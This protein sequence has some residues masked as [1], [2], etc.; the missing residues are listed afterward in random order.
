MSPLRPEKWHC[1]CDGTRVSKANKTFP[2][3]CRCF[4]FRCQNVLKSSKTNKH[5]PNRKDLYTFFRK[6]QSWRSSTD[7]MTQ[8]GNLFFPTRGTVRSPPL[9]LS[10]IVPKSPSSH[11][12]IVIICSWSSLQ[13][14]WPSQGLKNKS[15]DRP[16]PNCVWELPPGLMRRT[17]PGPV[18]FAAPFSSLAGSKGMM[19]VPKKSLSKLCS[20]ALC[21]KAAGVRNKQPLVGHNPVG[22]ESVLLTRSPGSS[23]K[24]KSSLFKK[25][26]FIALI[27]PLWSPNSDNTGKWRAI[28]LLWIYFYCLWQVG[29]HL[30][31]IHSHPSSSR[32]L[33]NRQ[34]FLPP[35]LQDCHWPR[36]GRVASGAHGCCLQA[37][38]QF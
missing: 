37:E 32:W 29:N 4:N 30:C 18:G 8:V 28:C 2:N 23:W 27:V 35:S 26:M 15:T 3:N 33:Q 16:E 36:G 19:M 13:N 5:H 24:W 10:P 34:Q 21:S 9:Q 20:K 31:T 6:L 17:L 25:N 38:V 1:D 14:W 12:V 11:E 22:L 7:S